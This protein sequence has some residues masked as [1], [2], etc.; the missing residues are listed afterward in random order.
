MEKHGHVHIS[1]LA[2][3]ETLL[4]GHCVVDPISLRALS[5]FVEDFHPSQAKILHEKKCI[6]TELCA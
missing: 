4:K 1:F 2:P 3:V 6:L 5:I